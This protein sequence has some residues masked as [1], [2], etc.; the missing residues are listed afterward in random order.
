MHVNTGLRQAIRS[1]A[2]PFF[3]GLAE[4]GGALARQ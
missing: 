2:E 4:L 3:D 1:V